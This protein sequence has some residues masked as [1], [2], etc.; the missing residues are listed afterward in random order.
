M[1]AARAL[2]REL[3]WDFDPDTRKKWTKA[4]LVVFLKAAKAQAPA[5]SKNK[6]HTNPKAS[7]HPSFAA[8]L[9]L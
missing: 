9:A 1:A 2:P 5:G 4:A 7:F 8:S 6:I 3:T